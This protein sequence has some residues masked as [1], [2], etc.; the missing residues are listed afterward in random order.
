MRMDRYK[1]CRKLQAAVQRYIEEDGEAVREF[2]KVLKALDLSQANH[3]LLFAIVF[4]CHSFVVVATYVETV[5]YY[6]LEAFR[7][8]SNVDV[9]CQA[10]MVDAIFPFFLKEYGLEYC[11]TSDNVFL[12]KAALRFNQRESH[13][14]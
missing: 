8:I 12:R 1:E 10:E 5:S 7:K 11:L 13:A 6:G 3:E 2:L 9:E 4:L 14:Q